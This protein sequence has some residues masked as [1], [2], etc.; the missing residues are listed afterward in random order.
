MTRLGTLVCVFLFSVASE[1][2]LAQDFH[3]SQISR[4]L[5]FQNPAFIGFGKSKLKSSMHYRSQW[6]SASSLYKTSALSAE[7]Q[8]KPKAMNLNHFG[9]GI[10]V[11]NDVAGDLN[12]KTTKAD[13]CLSY[14]QF[15]NRNIS[16]SAGIK[17]GFLQNSIDLTNARWGNQ[18]DGIGHN[19]N[20]ASNE[21]PDVVPYGQWDAGAGFLFSYLGSSA[22]RSWKLEFLQLG[23]AVQHLNHPGASFANPSIAKHGLLFNVQGFSSFS[24]GIKGIAVCPSF[25]Y[26]VKGKEQELVA[27]TLIRRTL[28]SNGS[29]E[30]LAGIHYRFIHDA[31]IPSVYINYKSFGFGLSYDINLSRLAPATNFRG[32]FEFSLKFISKGGVSNSDSHFP[33]I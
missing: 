16:V 24:S 12:L 8:L 30:L 17:F 29:L 26:Q 9:F 5:S 15:L 20:L 3:F 28:K 4:T 21:T 14:A 19:A 13:F 31:L 33:S 32:G 22:F 18:Y 11:L 27:G 6:R 7:V 1:N 25:Q 23:G 2:S 10:L